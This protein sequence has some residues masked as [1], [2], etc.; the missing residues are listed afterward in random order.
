MSNSHME[1]YNL[2]NTYKD[3]D[4]QKITLANEKSNPDKIVLLNVIKKEFLD[5]ADSLDK[6]K[7]CIDNLVFSAEYGNDM[8]LVTSYK[9][10]FPISKYIQY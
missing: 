8:L 4:Y 9:K 1:Q 3:D 2:L 10:G 6:F 7:N 5:D